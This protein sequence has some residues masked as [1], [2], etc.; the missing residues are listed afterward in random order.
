[1][2]DYHEHC[3]YCGSL[4]WTVTFYGRVT[5]KESCPHRLDAWHQGAP[6]DPLRESVAKALWEAQPAGSLPRIS[7]DEAKHPQIKGAGPVYRMADAAIRAVLAG[8]AA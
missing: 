2:S 6:H 4:D 1:M 5:H 3:N 8:G 7:W